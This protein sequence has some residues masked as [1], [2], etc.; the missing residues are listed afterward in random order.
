MEKNGINLAA[1]VARLTA[2]ALSFLYMLLILPH[3]A[4][5][6]P[7]N[8]TSPLYTS[9][10]LIAVLWMPLLWFHARTTGAHL[11]PVA[12][13]ASFAPLGLL[14]GFFALLFLGA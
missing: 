1:S 6:E 5:F 2:V 4:G 9:T 3:L 7:S 10:L 13:A 12:L 14:F 8:L 11:K